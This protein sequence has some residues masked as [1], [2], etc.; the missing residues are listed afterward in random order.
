MFVKAKS[1][2]VLAVTTFRTYGPNECSCTITGVASGGAKC[3]C[4]GSQ[5][6]DCT[7]GG[8]LQGIGGGGQEFSGTFTV[9][10]GKVNSIMVTS[11]GFKYVS[12]PNVKIYNGGDGCS[13]VEFYV[14]R[15][16]TP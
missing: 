9:A 8:T 15:L 10:D 2:G 5:G 1:R 14:T 6:T 7:A 13:G 3:S 11:P 12:A 4:L 16:S